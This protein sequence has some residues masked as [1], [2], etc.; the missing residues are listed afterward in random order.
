MQAKPPWKLPWK[1]PQLPHLRNSNLQKSHNNRPQQLL[2]QRHVV[3]RSHHQAS[4]A[5]PIC[6]TRVGWSSQGRKFQGEKGFLRGEPY[7]HLSKEME[8]PKGWW[9]FPPFFRTEPWRHPNWK[10]Q[11]GAD[12][13]GVLIW[14]TP[15]HLPD[16][17]FTCRPSK[18]LGSRGRRISVPT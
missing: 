15:P 14:Y 1:L 3:T 4:E 13:M 16:T 12:S 9:I 11:V 7:Q 2:P 10:V 8:N 6:L 17:W 5:P 18:I